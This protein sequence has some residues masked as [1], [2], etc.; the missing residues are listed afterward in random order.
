M[1]LHWE[2]RNPGVNQ[3]VDWRGGEGRGW[4]GRGGGHS[5]ELAGLT[6]A[7]FPSLPAGHFSPSPS[8]PP[9]LGNPQGGTQ[10]LPLLPRKQHPSPGGSFTCPC[11]PETHIPRFSARTQCHHPLKV[12][13]SMAS[14]QPWIRGHTQFNQH[15]ATKV[16]LPSPV[17]PGQGWGVDMEHWIQSQKT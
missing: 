1:S 15:L 16:L 14:S 10:G 2:D 5:E 7:T 4:P 3:V 6:S 17:G 13:I 11:P 9:A 8:Q 12:Q